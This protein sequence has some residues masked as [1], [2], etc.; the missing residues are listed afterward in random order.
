MAQLAKTVNGLAIASVKTFDGL[1]IASVKTILGVDNT[2]GYAASAT[3]LDGTDS[4]ER[5]A[6]LTG[7]ADGLEFSV[8]G[9]FKPTAGD[10][11]SRR[12]YE[13]ASGF[14]NIQIQA[15]NTL[16]VSINGTDSDAKVRIDQDSAKVAAITTSSGWTWYGISGNNITAGSVRRFYMANAATS[17]VVTEAAEAGGIYDQDNV[18][19]DYSRADHSIGA[20]VGGTVLFT[21]EVCELWFDF[22]RQIDWSS[23]TEQAKFIVAGKPQDLTGIYTPIMWFK[24]PAASFTTNS[25]GGGDF[26]LK[27]GGSFSPGTPP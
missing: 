22:T 7:V 14:M 5:D 25:G 8:S 24:N 21:G 13:S 19:L 15:D 20:A 18:N 17:W 4:M 9:W 2:G 26:V 23:G 6:D 12:I 10:G 1:A 16:R 11:T 3:I 27:G